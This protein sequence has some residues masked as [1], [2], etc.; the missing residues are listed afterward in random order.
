M[1]I[2]GFC[3][4]KFQ[5]DDISL[6]HT[7]FA[8]TI[9]ELL[10]VPMDISDLGRGTSSDRGPASKMQTLPS[11]LETSLSYSYL[12]PRKFSME[13]KNEWRGK[14]IPFKYGCF[15]DLCENFGGKL[16]FGFQV[17]GSKLV[18]EGC[19]AYGPGVIGQVHME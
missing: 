14:R 6:Q 5:N 10:D 18:F 3:W 1:L 17:S 11:R 7:N 9:F 8:M 16:L 4:V 15:G 19:N 12:Y 13:P 2:C